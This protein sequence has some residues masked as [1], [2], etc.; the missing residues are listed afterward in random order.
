M[1]ENN[2]NE[3]FINNQSTSNLYPSFQNI[4]NPQ[5]IQINRHQ[6]IMY[7][8]R[9]IADNTANQRR[10]NQDGDMLNIIMIFLVLIFFIYMGFVINGREGFD[11]K[12]GKPLFCMIVGLFL[13]VALLHRDDV[14]TIKNLKKNKNNDN[15]I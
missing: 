9:Q 2:N 10:R 4:D 6:D 12:T 5:I 11:T 3:S 1:K 13:L 7:Y 8:L 15:N 14:A